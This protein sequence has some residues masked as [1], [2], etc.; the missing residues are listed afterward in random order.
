ML[1]QALVIGFDEAFPLWALS[2]PDVGGLGWKAIEIGQVKL[3]TNSTREDTW[4][5]WTILSAR[6]T[7]D[8]VESYTLTGKGGQLIETDYLVV[9]A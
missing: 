3:T 5:K 4:S 7:V 9:Y 8:I 1:V 2:T 6:G